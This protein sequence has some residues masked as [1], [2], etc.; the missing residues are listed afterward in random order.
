MSSKMGPPHFFNQWRDL[1][2]VLV[3]INIRYTWDTHVGNENKR[4]EDNNTN[5]DGPWQG[6]AD[7]YFNSLYVLIPYLILKSTILGAFK[8]LSCNSILYNQSQMLPFHFMKTR[9]YDTT[10]TLLQHYEM[11]KVDQCSLP[12]HKLLRDF[13]D[14][15]HDYQDTN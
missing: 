7:F 10:R 1:R 14:N 8:R 15:Y 13:K 9:G 6:C 12:N 3:S 2:S 4:T 11:S 5:M